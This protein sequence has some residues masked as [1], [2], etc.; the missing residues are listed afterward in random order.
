MHLSPT[1]TPRSCSFVAVAASAFPAPAPGPVAPPTPERGEKRPYETVE[2]MK[3]LA[4]AGEGLATFINQ[5]V[6]DAYAGKLW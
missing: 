4:E 2:T 5:H 6:R 3:Q 1:S